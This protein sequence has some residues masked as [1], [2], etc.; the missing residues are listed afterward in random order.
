MIRII[1]L[2]LL[3]LSFSM[4]AQPEWLKDT[5]LK[6]AN[7]SVADKAGAAVLYYQNDMKIGGNSNTESH[8]RTAI[9]VF[10]EDGLSEATLSIPLHSWLKA[11]DVKGWL[12]RKGEKTQSLKKENILEMN[13]DG[14]SDNRI[15]Y[16]S[17]GE[18]KPGDVVGFEYKLKEKGWSSLFQRLIFQ[19]QNPVRF[20]QLT[21]KIPK[22]WVLKHYERNMDPFT[23]THTGNEYVWRAEDL[24]YRP[25][26]S[27]MPPWGYLMRKMDFVCFK[28]GSK[29]ERHFNDWQDVANW[30]A[31]LADE[32]VDVLP[33]IRSKT[34]NLVKGAATLQDSLEAIAHFVQRDIRYEAIEIKKGRFV[35]RKAGTT[36][37]NLFGDCK[38]KTTLMRAMLQSIG[39][40][41]SAV[42]ASVQSAAND[43][44]PTPFQ[45]D[46]CII[47]IKT[48]KLSDEHPYENAISGKW[49]FFDPTDTATPLGAIPFSLL[50][51]PLVV[52]TTEGDVLQRFPY[53]DPR[54]QYRRYTLDGVLQD[55][56]E[57]VMQVTIADYG[58]NAQE[59][60]YFRQISTENELRQSL[61]E[62][63][64]S[65]LPG[66][67]VAEFAVE[68]NGDSVLTRFN[69]KHTDFLKQ[70]PP[71]SVMPTG[72]FD[73]AELE[74][75]PSGKRIH[76]IW[77]GAP[78]EV[79]ITSRWVLP[80]TWKAD[81]DT[82]AI[83]QDIGAVRIKSR[84]KVAKNT[85]HIKKIYRNTGA[86]ID[87][88]E[89]KAARRLSS[90][91]EKLNNMKILIEK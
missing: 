21:L 42:L 3:V 54:K 38:D 52:C 81:I 29:N 4:V 71:Y 58:G 2:L 49:L 31:E 76:D 55:G 84:V 11:D 1:L 14:Y 22:G 62:Y 63:I 13:P 91:V 89:Y 16:G 72:I 19:I 12:L 67:K 61:A 34:S 88:G 47:A 50:G 36:L 15:L 73:L 75:L 78:S 17:F 85:V 8:I 44:L 30:Y 86:L 53:P 33:A 87:V 37:H 10:R 24:P 6:S 64:Q 23:F 28:P 7:Y 51:K 40:W 20:S 39:I 26:E 45:F 90:K 32:Q 77:F 5:Y 69:V 66:S 57:A 74:K 70:V 9:K 25:Q 59:Q 46:H 41:S 60:R 35:P 80:P 27:M 43:S 68:D 83:A 79:E 82:S 65:I 56:G 18:V 48:D